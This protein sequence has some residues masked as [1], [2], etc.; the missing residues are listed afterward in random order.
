MAT[1]GFGIVWMVTSRVWH[2]YVLFFLVLT[3]SVSTN[4]HHFHVFIL[5]YTLHT[6][7][8]PH[9]ST[10]NHVHNLRHRMICDRLCIILLLHCMVLP[11]RGRGFCSGVVPQ[12]P[13]VPCGQLATAIRQLVHTGS[14]CDSDSHYAFHHYPWHTGMVFIRW[15]YFVHFTSFIS[16]SPSN[17]NTQKMNRTQTYKLSS[18]HPPTNHRKTI[19]IAT[20]SR[21]TTAVA[22]IEAEAAQLSAATQESTAE[23]DATQHRESQ[24][25]I[26]PGRCHIPGTT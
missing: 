12:Q 7:H 8:L 10:T 3:D 9:F 17:T 25:Q 16:R 4:I 11:T 6:A 15:A 14:A 1:H 13:T 20:A 23:P 24:P 21:Q 5:H 19:K 2:S 18:A 26:R 22:A